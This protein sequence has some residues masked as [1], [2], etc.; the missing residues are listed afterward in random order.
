VKRLYQEHQSGIHEKLVDIMG[1]RA[2]VHVNAMKKIDWDTQ[3]DSSAVSPYM[4][5]LTKE[6]G[7]LQRVLAKHLPDM[8]VMMIMNPVFASYKGQWTKAFQDAT[9]KTET[10]KQRLADPFVTASTPTHCFHICV[11]TQSWL[12]TPV[13]PHWRKERR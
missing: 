1:A 5:T 10:G 4:E 8:T 11:F 9:L 2:I 13:T 6:T 3:A 7:T 12:S